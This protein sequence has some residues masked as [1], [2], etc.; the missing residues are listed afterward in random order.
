MKRAAQFTLGVLLLLTLTPLQSQNNVDPKNKISLSAGFTFAGPVGPMANYLIEKGFDAKNVSFSFFG[1]N[2]GSIDYPVKTSSGGSIALNYS[3]NV[4]E[5]KRLNLQIGFSDLG[6]ISG[7]SNQKGSIYLDF[8]SVYGSV[9]YSYFRKPWDLKIGPSVLL[10]T[11][12]QDEFS[13]DTKNLKET[14]L[15]IGLFIGL[16]L[17]IWDGNRT[18]GRLDCNYLFSI[19]NKIGPFRTNGNESDEGPPESNLSFAHATASFTFGIHL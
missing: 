7:Y 9:F 14:K 13:L 18:F 6:S 5:A 15:S 12:E 4:K 1:F 10:N 17:S 2:F 3:W 11:I 16:G 19:S 8:H